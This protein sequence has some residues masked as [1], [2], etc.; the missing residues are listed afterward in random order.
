MDGFIELLII[1]S[2]RKGRERRQMRLENGDGMSMEFLHHD[3][4]DMFMCMRKLGD[5]EG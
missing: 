3:S 2:V 1:C 5:F 4:H